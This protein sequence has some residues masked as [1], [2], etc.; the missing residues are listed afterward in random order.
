MKPSGLELGFRDCVF[1]EQVIDVSILWWHVLLAND[2][3]KQCRRAVVQRERHTTTAQVASTYSSPQRRLPTPFQARRQGPSYVGRDSKDER[4]WLYGEPE[5]DPMHLSVATEQVL[6]L[7]GTSRLAQ[8]LSR[9]VAEVGFARGAQVQVQ[10]V[11]SLIKFARDGL[12]EA[13]TGRVDELMG[14]P[15]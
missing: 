8:I 4:G 14:Y 12:Q 15:F 7:P 2:S 11:G 5:C 9:L 6:A 10:E 3:A 1:R 13:W